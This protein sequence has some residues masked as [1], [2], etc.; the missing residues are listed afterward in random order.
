MWMLTPSSLIHSDTHAALS[1]ICVTT[2]QQVLFNLSL[3]W[4]SHTVMGI[5][6]GLPQAPAATPQG[7]GGSYIFLWMLQ[8]PKGPQ[9]ERGHHAQATQSWPE[10]KR[11]PLQQPRAAG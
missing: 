4:K 5:T 9:V 11:I 8:V 1:I 3:G 2:C 10:A 6:G 7:H